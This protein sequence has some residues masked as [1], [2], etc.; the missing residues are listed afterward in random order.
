MIEKKEVVDLRRRWVEL[1]RGMDR[2]LAMRYSPLPNGRREKMLVS[3]GNVQD[4]LGLKGGYVPKGRWP[5]VLKHAEQ[6]E[7]GR[8]LLIWALGIER[9]AIRKACDGL[10]ILLRQSRKLTPVLLTDVADFAYFARL[11][12][13][14]EYLPKWTGAKAAYRDQKLSYLAWRYR[15]AL[16]V[17]AAAGC[18]DLA[19]SNKLMEMGQ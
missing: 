19:D 9:E 17:P 3:L 1:A 18:A 8:V 11:G 15:D 4:V 7:E 12:W 2:N 5:V 10:S 13:L 14:V 16:V 6:A